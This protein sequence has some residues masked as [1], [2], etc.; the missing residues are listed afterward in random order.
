MA[1]NN[2]KEGGGSVAKQTAP[3]NSRALKEVV[4]QVRLELTL[5]GF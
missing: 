4:P 2:V 1:H 5:D 3:E